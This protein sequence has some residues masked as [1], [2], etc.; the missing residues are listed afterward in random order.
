MKAHW[1]KMKEAKEEDPLYNQRQKRLARM[2]EVSKLRDQRK[3]DEAEQFLKKV[4]KVEK[5]DL[6]KKE[7]EKANEAKKTFAANNR[8]SERAKN[9][10]IEEMEAKDKLIEA[11]LKTIDK[12]SLMVNES[13]QASNHLMIETQEFRDSSVN[14]SKVSYQ[15]K[16]TPKDLR[17]IRGITQHYLGCVESP[18]PLVQAANKG[19]SPVLSLTQG[20]VGKS[21]YKSEDKR[22][23][24]E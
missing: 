22:Q 21:F 6:L 20:A 16:A 2:R 24:L 13:Y 5:A 8:E 4:E 19:K 23:K 1:N 14:M 11:H 15:W 3:R 17:E 12:L 7:L 10:L 18:R 9:S